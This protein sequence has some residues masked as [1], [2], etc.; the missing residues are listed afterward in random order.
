MTET[1]LSTFFQTY[2][3][4]IF[5]FLF[6]GF[7]FHQVSKGT[8]LFRPKIIVVNRSRAVSGAAGPIKKEMFLFDKQ[9]GRLLSSSS[10]R[11]GD[12]HRLA[13]LR[14]GQQLLLRPLLGFVIGFQASRQE[15]TAGL[16]D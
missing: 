2:C 8:K 7:C 12:R 1:F 13:A 10:F 3:N 16:T 14:L 6:V 11:K 5:S 9:R 4:Y 15:V